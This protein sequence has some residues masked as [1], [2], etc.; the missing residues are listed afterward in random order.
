MNKYLK[1]TGIFFGV[2][3]IA[4]LLNG[5]LSGISIALL[6]SSSVNDAM[7]NL[8]TSF[9]CSFVLSVPLV[10]LVWFVTIVAQVAEK[11]GDSL[12]Q[13]V[14][15]TALFCSIGGALVF[16][17]AFKMQFTNARYVAGLAIIISALVSVLFFRKQIKSNA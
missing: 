7:G 9:V 15:R 6:D 16:I 8:F 5:L 13:L 10:G 14:L 11:K 3:F 1:T 4:S 2:W 17:Y 12:F